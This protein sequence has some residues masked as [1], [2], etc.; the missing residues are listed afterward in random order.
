ME[1]VEKQVILKLISV[2]I[3]IFLCLG[4]IINGQKLRCENC[5]ISFTAKTSVQELGDAPKLS[6]Y[7]IN[8]TDLYDNFM[9]DTCLISFNEHGGFTENVRINK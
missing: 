3:L 7:K 9:N 4:I 6:E 2:T 5:Q 1:L 8:V